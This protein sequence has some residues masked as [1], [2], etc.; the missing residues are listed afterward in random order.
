V[1]QFTRNFLLG[2]ASIAGLVALAT[3][4][5]LFGELEA[6][7]RPRYLLTIDCTNAVG[8]RAGSTI[9]LNGVPVGQVDHV[10][11]IQHPEFPVRILA[12]ID[13]QV[14]IAE[15]V[16]LYATSSLLGGSAT[17][18]L[19]APASP[20]SPVLA[21]DGSAHLA[22]VIR[23]RLIAQLTSE[24]DA[25][26]G[27]VVEAMKEFEMLARNLNELVEPPDPARPRDARTIRTA[28]E[29]LNE[30][31]QDMHEAL[32]RA[33]ATID[34]FTRIAVGLE[35][36]AHTVVQQLTEVSEELTLTL[37]EARGL[38]RKASSGEGTVGQLINNPDLYESLD[39]AADR[40]ERTLRDL[41]L[42]LEKIRGDGL[43]VVW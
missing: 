14:Q 11:T 18:Q 35:T 33:T 38:A 43:R 1:T 17:L 26:M 39:D 6:V 27:P 31:L 34:E 21:T 32:T 42:L 19:E 29:T 7:L 5:L 40:M 37:Q 3:L 28:V 15:H 13:R 24:L 2:L 25:R 10:V 23:S 30:V 9:E 41:Q 20:G 8:L 36:D 16:A 12:L 22:D 4:L